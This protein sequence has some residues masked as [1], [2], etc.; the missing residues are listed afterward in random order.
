MQGRWTG[1]GAMLLLVV[2]NGCAMQPHRTQSS[3]T[4]PR[5]VVSMTVQG[6]PL[7]GIGINPVY[8]YF[9]VINYAVN[10]P[11]QQPTPMG[12]QAAPG[13]VAVFVPNG[14]PTGFVASSD[15]STF[16]YSDYV[17]FNNTLTQGSGFGLFHF[18]HPN[19]NNLQEVQTAFNGQPAQYAVVNGTTLQFT[20][21]L[22][23]LIKAY[24]QEHQINQ[25]QAQMVQQAQQIQ[26][27]QVN[28]IAT[29]T[30]DNTPGA[31]KATD[32]L[33]TGFNSNY[34]ILDLGQTLTSGGSINNGNA[35]QQVREP[36]GDVFTSG[37]VSADP[38]LDISD[39][40]IQYFTQ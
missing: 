18:V 11:N 5:L 10:L 16:G 19:P 28:F 20:I 4:G 38:S 39:W 32:A 13:P 23:Q 30:L 37:N 40:S 9:F 36:I 22:T 25:T 34:L 33:G 3:L 7:T 17:E 14:G 24:D 29:N 27:L 31:A 35:P 21:Y 6:S 2:A 15:G 1:F 26:F 12:T 8:Y